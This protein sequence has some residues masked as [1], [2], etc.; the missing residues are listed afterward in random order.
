MSDKPE[1]DDQTL[2]DSK[3][4]LALDLDSAVD[5]PV[6]APVESAKSG[7]PVKSVESGMPGKSTTPAT[8]KVDPKKK[9]PEVIFASQYIAQFR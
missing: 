1:S 3:T 7:K 4:A 5:A 2:E 8:A 6:V 9:L